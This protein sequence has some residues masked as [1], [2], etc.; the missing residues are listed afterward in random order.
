MRESFY[1]FFW[2]Y[3]KTFSLSYIPPFSPHI[4]GACFCTGSALFPFRN[5]HLE[6]VHPCTVSSQMYRFPTGL[7]WKTHTVHLGGSETLQQHFCVHLASF[8]L[9]H[10]LYL[11][12]TARP[13]PPSPY[14]PT[15]ST[16]P[17]LT[18]NILPSN[19]RPVWR[20][21]ANARGSRSSATTTPLGPGLGDGCAGLHC[22][23]CQYPS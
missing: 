5:G 13:A 16:L 9:G 14:G 23:C 10:W 22:P 1:K 3:R 7:W 11:F 17:G 18:S 6:T 2:R 20:C 12:G 19:P 21:K 8:P 4:R 15:S